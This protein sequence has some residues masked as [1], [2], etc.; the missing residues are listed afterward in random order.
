MMDE[1]CLIYILLQITR[2]WP[3]RLCTQEIDV[4]LLQFHCIYAPSWRM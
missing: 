1:K 4:M 3:C 2:S